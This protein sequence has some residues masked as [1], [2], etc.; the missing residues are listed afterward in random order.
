MSVEEAG[1]RRQPGHGIWSGRLGVNIGSAALNALRFDGNH[2]A[3]VL[4]H[5]MRSTLPNQAAV[6]EVG[7][8]APKRGW[9]SRIN[10]YLSEGQAPSRP[11]ILEAS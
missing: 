2:T 5:R 10:D 8:T 3:A 11:D 1:E 6:H 9:L 4:H 7:T